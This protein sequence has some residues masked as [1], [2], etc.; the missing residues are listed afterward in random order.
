M[1]VRPHTKSHQL[2]QLCIYRKLKVRHSLVV[3]GHPRITS[4]PIGAIVVPVSTPP[5][6]EVSAPKS[7]EEVLVKCLSMQLCHCITRTQTHTHT[8]TYAHTPMHTHKE[9]VFPF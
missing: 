3:S 6:S 5:V 7:G 8:H 2:I 9:P 4:I 1:H